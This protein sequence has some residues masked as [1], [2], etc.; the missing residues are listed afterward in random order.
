MGTELE[1]QF[2]AFCEDVEAFVEGT[3][4]VARRREIETF[5]EASEEARAILAEFRE[6]NALF[7]HVEWEVPAPQNLP[8]AQEILTRATG[9]PPVW[10]GWWQSFWKLLPQP[11]KSPVF[12]SVLG[13]CAVLGITWTALNLN[14]RRDLQMA[15]APPAAV[16]KPERNV[17]S[18]GVVQPAESTPVPPASSPVANPAP[19]TATRPDNDSFAADDKGNVQYSSSDAQNGPQQPRPATVSEEK[20]DLA[21]APPAPPRDE[22]ASGAPAS[23]ALGQAAP[24]VAA[25]GGSAVGDLKKKGDEPGRPDAD[26][27][28]Q[29]LRRGEYRKPADGLVVSES[30]AGSKDTK[31][32]LLAKTDPGTGKEKSAQTHTL[33]PAK[34]STAINGQRPAG[35]TLLLDGVEASDLSS[36]KL[37]M[38]SANL[39]SFR[40]Q[41]P[42]VTKENGGT[43]ISTGDVNEKI[44]ILK[45]VVPADQIDAYLAR[46]GRLGS[47]V[48]KQVT[49]IRTPKEQDQPPARNERENVPAA[50]KAK[51]TAS[52]KESAKRRSAQMVQVEVHVRLPKPKD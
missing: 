13:V 51:K 29:E 43:T 30:V 24:A 15:S 39:E 17:Q 11:V 16:S 26:H 44:L 37:E 42:D 9:T 19:T 49:K 21:A 6:A 48:R 12:A 2:E 32:E 25:P 14:P 40:K 28:D 22:A 8:T 35:N 45:A 33:P 4:P 10:K 20:A 46:V 23:K 31:P 18:D 34:P 38:T 27:R 36:V 3:L 7:E 1:R 41:F 5:L 47:V 50:G 52:D